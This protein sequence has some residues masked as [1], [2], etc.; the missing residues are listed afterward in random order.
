VQGRVIVKSN[1]FTSVINIIGPLA[2]QITL[3]TES[4][5]RRDVLTAINDFHDGISTATGQTGSSDKHH[6]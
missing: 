6:R 2:A 4:R 5:Y 1:N 3:T